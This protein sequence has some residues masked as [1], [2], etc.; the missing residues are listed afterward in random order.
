[1]GK[2]NNHFIIN[3]FPML[4]KLLIRI[5]PVSSMDSDHLFAMTFALILVTSD[6]TG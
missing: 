1:M 4:L 3:K 5:F 2:D 6:R